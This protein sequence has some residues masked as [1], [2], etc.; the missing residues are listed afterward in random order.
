MCRTGPPRRRF[1]LGRQWENGPPGRPSCRKDI[2]RSHVSVAF[3]WFPDES[4]PTT[5]SDSN[6]RRL[7][8]HRNLTYGSSRETPECLACWRSCVCPG[9]SRRGLESATRRRSGIRA[10][11]GRR[12]GGLG[13]RQGSAR[14]DADPRADFTQRALAM[15]TGRG[16]DGTGPRGGLGI[17]QGSRQLAGDQQLHAEG[18]ADRIRPSGMDDADVCGRHRRLVRARV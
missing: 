17:F 13:Q 18:F 5:G 12:A 8:D 9:R 15:A 3:P 14:D 11:A 7:C 1:P 6:S 4:L 2:P 10:L 16:A